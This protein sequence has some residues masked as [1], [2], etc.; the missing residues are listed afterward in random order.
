M[1]IANVDDILERAPEVLN[2]FR[3]RMRL[4]ALVNLTCRDAD[5]PDTL[6]V[7]VQLRRRHKK[8]WLSWHNMI[9]VRRRASLIF[10]SVAR[11]SV[12]PFELTP[13]PV[14]SLSSPGDNDWALHLKVKS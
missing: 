2:H 12:N 6:P 7:N 3:N 1:F 8:L 13:A 10:S 14:S 11:V 4:V 9:S 5:A